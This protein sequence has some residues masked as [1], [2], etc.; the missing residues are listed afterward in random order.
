MSSLYNV[1][2]VERGADENELKKAYKK[3]ALQHHPDKG[4]DPEEFKKIQEAH[5]V[6]SDPDKRRHYDMTGKIPGAAE[7]SGPPPGFPFGNPFGGF[8]GGGP[9]DI[10]ELFGMFGRGGPGPRAPPRQNERRPGKPGPKVSPVPLTLHDF[11]NGRHITINFDRNRFCGPCNGRGS[12]V[13]KPCDGCNGVGRVMRI[14]QMGPGMMMQQDMQCGQCQG[15]GNIKGENCGE[16][17]GTCF[18]KDSKRIDLHVKPGTKVGTKITFSGE[19]SNETEF[20]EA[21]DVII[22]LIEADED[23]F[24]TRDGENLRGVLSITM[25]KA[26]CGTIECIKDHPGYAEG[27]YVNMPAGVQNG[28]IVSVFGAG[29][30]TENNSGKGNAYLTVHVRT[31]AEE[32]AALEANKEVLRGVFGIGEAVIPEN[33]LIG[34]EEGC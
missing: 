25:A 24:W 9:I 34:R 29:M 16:C 18:K 26:L 20:Q 8:G 17:A 23:I 15:S 28:S 19:S 11:Y 3:L 32:R 4:G 14:M 10:S 1:L 27:L 21:G 33:V 22:E 13:F 31:T 30:P 6:L 7:E 5:A 12:T 2:G